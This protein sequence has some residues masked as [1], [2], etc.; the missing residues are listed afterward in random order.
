MV[1]KQIRFLWCRKLQISYSEIFARR[2]RVDRLYS[3]QSSSRYYSKSGASTALLCGLKKSRTRRG[4]ELIWWC[5]PCEWVY[6][7]EW[8]YIYRGVWVRDHKLGQ[9]SVNDR[10][11]RSCIYGHQRELI[12][13]FRWEHNPAIATRSREKWCCVRC[14]CEEEWLANKL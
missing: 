1:E 9:I 7:S 2:S 3:S 14:L 6:D 4:T 8:C 12:T 11:D 5:E 10:G 13:G